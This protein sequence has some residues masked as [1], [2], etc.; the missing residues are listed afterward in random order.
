MCLWKTFVPCEFRL[1]SSDVLFAYS[2]VHVRARDASAKL[3]A[4]THARLILN[5][6]FLRARSLDEFAY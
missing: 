1:P 5:L 4:R 2:M 6:N 3:T